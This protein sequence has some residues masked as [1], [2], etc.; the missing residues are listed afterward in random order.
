[1]HAHSSSPL[2][3][4][5]PYLQNR[6]EGVEWRQR[7]TCRRVERGMEE[8][9][10]AE[11]CKG[12]GRSTSS[13][14]KRN[15]YALFVSIFGDLLSPSLHPSFHPLLHPR[16]ALAPPSQKKQWKACTFTL[17]ERQNALVHPMLVMAL[18]LLNHVLRDLFQCTLKS[19][20]KKESRHTFLFWSLQA[21][22]RWSWKRQSQLNFQVVLKKKRLDKKAV[23]MNYLHLFDVHVL[24][25][26]PSAFR[27]AHRPTLHRA[28]QLHLILSAFHPCSLLSTLSAPKIL[29]GKRNEGIERR[30]TCRRVE[31]GRE[32]KKPRES[33]KGRR[34]SQGV[35]RA[36]DVNKYS[37]CILV[38]GI[39]FWSPSPHPTLHSTI[40]PT[41]LHP[42]IT[43]ASSSP[44]L[45]N[46]IHPFHLPFHPQLSTCFTPFLRL[47]PL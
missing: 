31:R 43:L 23:R 39:N 33:E 27:Y 19:M 45:S 12:K 34:E 24:F 40:T 25:L 2:C 3:P 32:E 47:S 30:W 6:N 41:S 22:I 7:W 44:N 11:K 1:M 28:P 36:K 17:P 26:H 37:R 18:L 46:H 35:D 29:F 20:S 21:N 8:N 4:L 5:A 10:F 9:K 16:F 13:S 15:K 38:L 42:R 14:K